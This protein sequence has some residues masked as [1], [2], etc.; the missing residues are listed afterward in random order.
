MATNDIRS[1]LKQNLGF[2]ST[3]TSNTTT[4][5]AILDTADFELG[6]MFGMFAA[7]FATG[8]FELVLEESDDENMAGAVP[9]TGDKLIGALPILTAGTVEGTQLSTVGVIS[10]L[11]FV[12]PTIVSTGVTGS[13]VIT[14]VS[15]EKAESMP[16]V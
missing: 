12:R 13:S 7:T 16:V 1:N 11:R 2:T 9:I 4:L 3:I 14:V 15:T 5:G 10:N 8:N 6:L